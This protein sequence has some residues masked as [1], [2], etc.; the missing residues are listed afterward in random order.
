V[1]RENKQP[2]GMKYIRCGWIVIGYPEQRNRQ[3]GLF[4]GFCRIFQKKC[5]VVTV[6]VERTVRRS[7]MVDTGDEAAR[8]HDGKKSFEFLAHGFGAVAHGHFVK[9]TDK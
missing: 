5:G 8:F 9:G 6:S 3:Y 2:H 4:Y 7:L 1:I